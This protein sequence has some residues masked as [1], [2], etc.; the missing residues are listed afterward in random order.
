M[1]GNIR[2]IVLEY[3]AK[4][5]DVSQIQIKKQLAKLLVPKSTIKLSSSIIK[6]LMKPFDEALDFF[7]T[8][9]TQEKEHLIS[10]INFMNKLVMDKQ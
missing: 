8:N 9:A 7:E 3:V 2:K 6:I 4:F 10:H 1:T 5:D